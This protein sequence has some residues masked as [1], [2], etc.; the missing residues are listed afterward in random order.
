MFNTNDWHI[1]KLDNSEYYGKAYYNTNMSM[2]LTNEHGERL[3][4]QDPTHTRKDTTPIAR[5]YLDTPM[6]E[7]PPYA[8]INLSP[9][10]K[11]SRMMTEEQ[12]KQASTAKSSKKATKSDQP[13]A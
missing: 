8:Y 6:E 11:M 7:L 10:W 5:L 1:A 3:S 13:S 12:F 9:A 4:M 2:S